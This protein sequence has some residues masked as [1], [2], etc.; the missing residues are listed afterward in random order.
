MPYRTM[1]RAVWVVACLLCTVHSATA[2]DTTV[3][4]SRVTCLEGTAG[5]FPCRDVDLL[6]FVH[7]G[8][9]AVP[10][11]L[12][13]SALNDLWGW[14]DPDTGSEYALVG[15][16]V[17][18]AFVDVSD[19]IRP[20]VLGVLPTH[21]EP[22]LWRDVK[23]YANH[24]LVVADNAGAHGLQIFDLTQLRGVTDP[25][26][27][28][29]ETA[30]Y[31]EFE[32]AHNVAVNE[33]TGYAY[34]VGGETCGGGLHMIDLGRPEEPSPTTP[35]F[36]GCFADPN[37]EGLGTHPPGYTH[38]VQCV[39]YEG[40]DQEH[41]GKEICF[42]SNET[43]ISI[44]DVSD[45]E[46]PTSLATGTYPDV[47]YVHQG[48]LTEDHRYFIQNDESDELQNV[49]PRT[50]TLVWDV[51]D[52]DAPTL[53]TEYLGPTTSTDHNLYVVGPLVYEANYTSGLRIVDVRD[54]EEPEE[55][56]FFDT[57][58]AHDEP[59]FEGAWS[60]YPFFESG[61]V[62]VSSIE[63]GLFVLDP[64]TEVDVGRGEVGERPAS[65]AVSAAYPNPFRDRTVLSL[66]L[67]RSQPVTATLFDVRGRRVRTVRDGRLPAGV[68][69][70]EIDG[71]GLPS[72]PYVL[73]IS[74]RDVV[75]TQ[76]VT[77]V[78]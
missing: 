68:H 33:D 23:V 19:P 28:F 5:D 35:S 63:E 31:D 29:T 22:S 40:P 72:G 59:G 77:R 16:N 20:Q 62:I 21:T 52:L 38:D 12:E 71:T 15:T 70:L 45:K 73:R 54:V 76:V 48:W 65:F 60:V 6:S 1:G 7:V 26:V 69:V 41:R 2:Q 18:I 39:I 43:A 25:P 17:G 10:D 47:G 75:R 74:G 32:E 27:P 49:V 36:A 61:T 58:P 3:T 46:N 42:G 4:G 55:L 51:T 64:T 24:A 56:G 78:R 37:T 9:L 50:R 57:F 13:P 34:A 66:H 44:A 11:T 67:D 30:H 8:D 53:I 14:T